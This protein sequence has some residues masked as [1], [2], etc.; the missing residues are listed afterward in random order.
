MNPIDHALDY[1]ARGL[2]V[3][4]CNPTPT[5]PRAKTPLTPR[6][7]KDATTDPDLIRAWWHQWPSALIGGAM[8]PTS[9]VFAV[10]PDVPKEPGD[11][12]GLAAWNALTEQHG[13]V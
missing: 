12:N 2:P 13:G 5:K 10:D 7:F 8:G 1:A 3:F 4:P 6:G 11:P 9:G